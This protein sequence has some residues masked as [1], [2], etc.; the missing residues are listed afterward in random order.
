[1][2]AVLITAAVVILSAGTAVAG[3]NPR[4]NIEV[5]GTIHPAPEHYGGYLARRTGAFAAWHEEEKARLLS[6]DYRMTLR[7]AECVAKYDHG[8]SAEKVLRSP[9]GSPQDQ[10]ALSWLAQVN[11]ACAA[12][13]HV[14][15]PLLLRAALAETR[16]KSAAEPSA[17]RKRERVGVPDVV[18][19]YPLASISR[20]QLQYAPELVESVMATQPG[21]AAE[22][23]AAD[24][25]FAR[26]PQCG[27][28][29]LGRLTATAARLALVDAAYRRAG[30]R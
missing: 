26:T 2:R 12:E 30:G 22:R 13:R 1:M 7:F 5:R 10:Q 21:E 29:T 4:S 23:A 28:K 3:P 20:C 25:L 24:A 8:A 16:I 18:D 9:I 6:Y 17:D 11:R 15:H 27:A 19:G 14:V